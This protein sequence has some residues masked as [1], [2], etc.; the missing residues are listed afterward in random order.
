MDMMVP[1]QGL[2]FLQEK[3][4]VKQD[5]RGKLQKRKYKLTSYNVM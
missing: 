4:R 1:V 5:E 3:N 2:I